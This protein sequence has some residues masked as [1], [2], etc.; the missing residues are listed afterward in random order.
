MKSV[1]LALA[2][3]AAAIPAHAQY[4]AKEWPEGAMKQRFAR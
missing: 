2:F 4:T 1:L 3:T